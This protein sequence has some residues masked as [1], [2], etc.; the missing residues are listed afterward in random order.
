MRK[1][2]PN[3]V[4]APSCSEVSNAYTANDVDPRPTLSDVMYIQQCIA[5]EMMTGL[6]RPLLRVL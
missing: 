5:S 1:E 4:G 6:K 2:E 3:R